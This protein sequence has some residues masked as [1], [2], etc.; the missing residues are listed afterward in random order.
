M[1]RVHFNQFKGYCVPKPGKDADKII[2]DHFNPEEDKEIITD[3]F[4]R[5]KWETSEDQG[6]TGESD[7]LGEDEG[8]EEEKEEGQTTNDHMYKDEAKIH[9]N[10][11]E[12]SNI[13]ASSLSSGRGNDGSENPDEEEEGEKTKKS[14]QKRGKKSKKSDKK[15]KIKGKKS[16]K[17]TKRK[18]KNKNDNY[19]FNHVSDPSKVNKINTIFTEILSAFQ[20]YHQIP[21]S[22]L[23]N[24]LK[25]LQFFDISIYIEDLLNLKDDEWLNDNNIS[26]IY[27]YLERYQLQ[28]YISNNLIRPSSICLLRPSMVYLLANTPNP[29]SCLKGVIPELEKADFI[30]LPINDSTDVEVVGDGSHWSLVVVSMIDRSVKLYDTLQQANQRESMA[31]IRKLIEYLN[32]DVFDKDYFHIDDMGDTTPQQLN[33]SD[34]GILTSQ[35]TAFLVSRLLD[36]KNLQQ[37]YVNLDLDGVKISS[38]DGRIFVLRTILNVLKYKLENRDE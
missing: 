27:E 5:F 28:P 22:K 26:F 4:D 18:S 29:A 20:E 36:L 7:G 13:I 25:I 24:D 6:S 32:D 1:L 23:T 33:G 16:G 38:I 2:A 34:C 9:L 3:G 19:E 17:P 37:C 35:I 30:F 21:K 14:K 10:H 15:D 11:E 8:E 31:V 12:D